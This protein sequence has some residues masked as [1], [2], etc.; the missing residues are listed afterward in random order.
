MF[1]YAA[2]TVRVVDGD[3]IYFNVDLGFFVR[4]TIQVRLRGVNTPEMRGATR[5][6]GRAAR[7]YT[8]AA[9]P[10][11]GQVVI[12]TYKLEK[13]GRYLADVLYAPGATSRQQV[14]AAPRLLNQELID[15]GLAVAYMA[16]EIK[17]AAAGQ[18]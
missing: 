16:D 1:E 2:E 4:I 11:G 10:V 6:Q 3:T 15:H 14:L 13:Y 12:R 18:V 9:L 17:L 7:A 8:E 5:E